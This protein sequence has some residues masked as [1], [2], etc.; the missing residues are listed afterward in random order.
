MEERLRKAVEE[1]IARYNAGRA[2]EAVAELLDLQGDEARVRFT[3]TF[4]RT[5]GVYDY[6]EDLLGYIAGEILGFEPVPEGFV[7]RFRFFPGGGS[8]LAG[9]QGAR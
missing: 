8:P 4:C 6:F 1:A 7:V 9:E 5:C 3:G 2:P